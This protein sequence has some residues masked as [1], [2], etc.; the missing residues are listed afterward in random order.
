MASL[1]GRE[2]TL[3][4]ELDHRAARVLELEALVQARDLGMGFNKKS[5]SGLQAALGLLKTDFMSM[6]TEYVQANKEVSCLGG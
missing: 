6:Q 5:A 3:Q 2:L 4:G 1:I